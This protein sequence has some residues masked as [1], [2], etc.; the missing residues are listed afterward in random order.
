VPADYDG[1]GATDVA[2]YRNAT[3]EWFVA[4]SSGGLGY[5]GWGAPWLGDIPVPGDYDGDSIADVAV[6]RRSTAGWFIRRAS[7]D[8]TWYSWGGGSD[9]PVPGDYDGDGV[10]DVA[11]YRGPPDV[12]LVRT[13]YTV[14]LMARP[15]TGSGNV[16]VNLSTA[17]RLLAMP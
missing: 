2:V 5:T 6:Y 7:G 15:I 12:F 11:I 8:E 3:G 1:D 10:T 14:S 17:V 9:L 13:S 16:P 4:Y